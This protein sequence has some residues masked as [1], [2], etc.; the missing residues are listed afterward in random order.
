MVIDCLDHSLGAFG[1]ENSRD[2]AREIIRDYLQIHRNRFAKFIED[3]LDNYI[4]QLK[5]IW[6][7]EEEN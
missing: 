2:I 4:D 5:K 3:N 1:S 7:H 6:E